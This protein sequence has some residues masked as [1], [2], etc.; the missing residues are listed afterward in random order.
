MDDGASRDAAERR[1][2]LLDGAMA[3]QLVADRLVAAGWQV[4]AR[5]WRG[6]GGEL[7]LVV[8]RMGRLRFVEVKARAPDDPVGLEAIDQGKRRRLA[9]AAK[10]FLAEWDDLVDEACFTVALVHLPAGTSDGSPPDPAGLT[11]EWIDDAFDA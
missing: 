1:R 6:A 10:A 2:A 8:A 5:N 3:E 11:V 9:Q 4:L 7:D